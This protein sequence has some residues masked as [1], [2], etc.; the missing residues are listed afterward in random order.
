MQFFVV[1]GKQTLAIRTPWE[2]HC[3]LYDLNCANL[4]GKVD[5]LNVYK[6]QSSNYCAYFVRK[7]KKLS[8]NSPK[9]SSKKSQ[10]CP[11]V[12]SKFS[13]VV[14]KLSESCPKLFQRCLMVVSKLYQ[15]CFKVVLKMSQR[16][17]KVVSKLHQSCLQVVTNLY[18]YI[19]ICLK[20]A[21]K[22]S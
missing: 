18:I 17:R 15:S 4:T 21:S 16:C 19:V 10:C 8:Q 7:V 1:F 20:L 6:A 11:T 12:F 2:T 14:S 22:L 13:K 3:C 9:V 5:L